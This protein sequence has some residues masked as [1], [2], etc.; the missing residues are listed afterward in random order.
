MLSQHEVWPNFFIVGAMKSGTTSLYEHLKKH[1]QVFFP[2][3]K[4][5]HYFADCQAPADAPYE[6]ARDYYCCNNRE[7]YLHLYA[8]SGGFA[9]AGDASPSYLWDEKAPARIHSVCPQARI[10]AIL[11]DPIL[12]AHSQYLMNLFSGAES[13]PFPEALRQDSARKNRTW[14]T[15]RLYV[16]FGMYHD[17][18]RRYIDIFG[19]EQVLVLLFDD[20]KK[21]PQELFAS[22]ARH[23]GIDPQPPETADLSEAHNPYRMPRAG[24]LYR[25]ARKAISRD[26]RNRIFP[27]ALQHWLRYTPLLYDRRKPPLDDESRAI[28]QEIYKPEIAKVEELLDRNLPE[29][30][31]SWA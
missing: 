5:P 3:L 15:A 12:R 24:G 23:I 7:G 9:A 17:Q 6:V 28:L 25:F 27:P 22:V 16:D 21:S 8:S 13:L 30:R 10:I 29:L 4:E 1:P 14:W 20:L 2:E 18:L 19:R 31:Q 26:L 11:R